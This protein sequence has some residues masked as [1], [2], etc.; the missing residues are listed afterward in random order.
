MAFGDFGSRY[1]KPVELEWAAVD[2]NRLPPRCSG[3]NDVAANSL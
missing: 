1:G 2:S 3:V